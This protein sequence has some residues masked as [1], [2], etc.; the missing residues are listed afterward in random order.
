MADLGVAGPDL[1]ALA[2]TLKADHP[3]IWAELRKSLTQSANGIRDAERAAVRGLTFSTEKTTRTGGLRRKTTTTTQGS[4]KT[5][6]TAAAKRAGAKATTSYAEAAATGKRRVTAKQW[7]K[8]KA[9]SGLRES[10]ARGIRTST[11]LSKSSGLKV[12]VRTSASQMPAGQKNLPRLVNAGRWRHPVFA[13]GGDRKTWTWV[14]QKPDRVG[15]W[16]TTAEGQIPAATVAAGESLDRIT[17]LIAA[18]A[19]KAAG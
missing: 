17:E 6:G 5:G 9:R 3:E 16:W 4:G 12:T 11:T 1:D 15:W 19:S 13:K 10:I 8:L 14:Y 7:T 2:R 18:K